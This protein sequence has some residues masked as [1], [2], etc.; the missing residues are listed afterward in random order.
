MDRILNCSLVTGNLLIKLLTSSQGPQESESQL[1]ENTGVTWCDVN[2][3]KI[4]GPRSS[5]LR[6]R[7]DS[8][9]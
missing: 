5:Y 2:K 7:L 3:N 6:L 8:K 9:K 1:L 4:L